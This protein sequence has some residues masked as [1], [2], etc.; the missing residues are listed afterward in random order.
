VGVRQL[1]SYIK[2]LENYRRGDPSP[3]IAAKRVWIGKERKTRSIYTILWQPFLAASLKANGAGGTKPA[4]GGDAQSSAYRSAH[5]PPDTAAA[6]PGSPIKDDGLT[7]D[8]APAGDTQ[9][10][11]DRS[12]GAARSAISAQE[13]NA[14]YSARRSE[15]EVQDTGATLR[16]MPSEDGCMPPINTQFSADQSGDNTQ[17]A[18][19]ARTAIPTEDGSR[20]P[21]DVPR[22]DAQFSARRSGE[23]T[24]DAVGAQVAISSEEGGAVPDGLSPS[25]TQS[26]AH[27]FG[28]TQETAAARPGVPNEEGGA[29][30][31]PAILS[32]DTRAVADGMPTVDGAARALYA[33][34]QRRRQQQGQKPAPVPDRCAYQPLG[35]GDCVPHPSA[36]PC[37]NC[38]ARVNPAHMIIRLR[39][40]LFCER[41]CPACHPAA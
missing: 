40:G 33:N 22:R 21:N 37:K 11:A 29:V 7:P 38:G 39:S 36:Q 18:T 5:G 8:C 28:D 24:T 15:G 13:G 41:C 26:S 27:R 20:I 1:Q 31:Q 32:V 35:P 17:E 34:S 4:D 30:S 9:F 12:E 3:L 2:E 10:S 19:A 23:D 25:D 14:Q 6:R 16:G